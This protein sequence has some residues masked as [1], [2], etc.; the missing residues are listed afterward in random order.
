[1]TLTI[2]KNEQLFE[3]TGQINATTASYFKCHFVIA[4]NSLSGLSIDINKVIEIDDT[5]MQ[6][7]KTIY[8]K[9]EQWKKPFKIIGFGSKDIYNELRFQKT[10]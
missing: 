3:V 4:L 6:A 5:G 2:T 9:A 7:I 1:M 10:A 8:T